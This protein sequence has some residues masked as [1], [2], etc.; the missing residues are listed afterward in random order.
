MA[1]A[2][3]ALLAT[4]GIFLPS[5]IFVLIVNPIVPRLRSS[6]IFSAFLD[7]VNISALAVMLVV[8]IKLGVQVLI[9]WRTLLIAALSTIAFFCIKKINSAFIVLSGAVLGYLLAL[10][11]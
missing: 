10:L 2:H 8:G 9:D 7:A 6:K 1:G 4:L 3:G 5:F 11:S